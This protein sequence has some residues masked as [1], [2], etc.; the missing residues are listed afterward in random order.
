MDQESGG[1]WSKTEQKIGVSGVLGV[2]GVS[3]SKQETAN[4]EIT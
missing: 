2:S 3:G 4:G 1:F